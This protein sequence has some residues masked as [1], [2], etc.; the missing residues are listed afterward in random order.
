MTVRSLSSYNYFQ[1]ITLFTKEDQTQFGESEDS[2][3]IL[4]IKNQRIF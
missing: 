1:Y 2:M 4:K 3:A